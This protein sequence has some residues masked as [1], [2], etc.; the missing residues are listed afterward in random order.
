MLFPTHR[1]PFRADPH[2]WRGGTKGPLCPERS[3]VVRHWSHCLP[4][5]M[6]ASSCFCNNAGMFPFM[7][8]FLFVLIQ[9]SAQA[10]TVSQTHIPASF[11]FAFKLVYWACWNGI[12]RFEIPTLFYCWEPA[13]TEACPQRWVNRLSSHT[14]IDLP[15]RSEICQRRIPGDGKT[16]FWNG[17]KGCCFHTVWTLVRGLFSWVSEFASPFCRNSPRFSLQSFIMPH[18]SFSCPL[19]RSSFL[20]PSQ[21]ENHLRCFLNASRRSYCEWVIH[22]AIKN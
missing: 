8:F 14:E 4:L 22:A 19:V 6:E 3:S 15:Q 9:T 2:G 12:V 16:C 1:C 10:H 11:H 21:M 13:V 18:H 17:E 20:F 5:S 7:L